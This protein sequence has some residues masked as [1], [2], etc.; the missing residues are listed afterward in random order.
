MVLTL[1][2]FLGSF[3]QPG[4]VVCLADKGAKMLRTLQNSARAVEAIGRGEAERYYWKRITESTFE[5][6][7]KWAELTRF[8]DIPL[9][10][11]SEVIRSILNQDF[12]QFL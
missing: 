8:E 7:S 4:I 9:N 11:S 6:T 5:V 1:K 10:M 12:V 2:H 3:G